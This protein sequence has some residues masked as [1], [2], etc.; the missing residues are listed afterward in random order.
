MNFQRARHIAD[1]PIIKALLPGQ[2]MERQVFSDT[3]SSQGEYNLTY[4][5]FLRP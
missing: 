1:K 5:Y 4:K 3:L 2:K